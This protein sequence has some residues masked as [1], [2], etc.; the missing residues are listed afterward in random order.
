MFRSCIVDVRSYRKVNCD[1]D[2]FLLISTF[3]LKIRRHKNKVRRKKKFSV[4][5]GK[6][7]DIEILRNYSNKITDHLRNLEGQDLNTE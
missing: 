5:L 3:K 2:H 4:Q 7:K 6:L 1:T